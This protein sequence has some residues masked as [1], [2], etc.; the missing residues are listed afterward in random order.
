MVLRP[1]RGCRYYARRDLPER[2]LRATDDI[3]LAVLGISEAHAFQ[4]WQAGVFGVID[5]RNPTAHRTMQAPPIATLESP[6]TEAPAP[7]ARR[8]KR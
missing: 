6:T 2:G 8:S 7:R 3:D 4:F 1:T 5:E